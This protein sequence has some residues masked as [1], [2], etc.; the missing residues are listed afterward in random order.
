MA[1]LKG[2]VRS[3]FSGVELG[4]AKTFINVIAY[5]D[6][7]RNDW[8]HKSTPLI[9]KN[10]TDASNNKRKDNKTINN[11]VVSQKAMPAIVDSVSR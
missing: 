3:L 7:L 1:E 5:I 4:D 9:R 8:E 11:L 10:S 6:S 2:I